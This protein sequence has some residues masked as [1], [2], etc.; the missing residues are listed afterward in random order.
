[1]VSKFL[2]S[3]IFQIAHQK[4]TLKE[5]DESNDDIYNI[6]SK[7]SDEKST[8]AKDDEDC[9]SNINELKATIALLTKEKEMLVKQNLEYVATIE[10]LERQLLFTKRTSTDSTKD[11]SFEMLN[12]SQS[13]LNG[14]QD[15]LLSQKFLLQSKFPEDKT[16]VDEDNHM[17]LSLS[18]D[19]QDNLSIRHVGSEARDVE[20]GGKNVEH[21]SLSAEA[22]NIELGL[23]KSSSR[24]VED[25]YQSVEHGPFSVGDELQNVEQ[26]SKFVDD[27][28]EDD[29]D[30]FMKEGELSSEMEDIFRRYTQGN[31]IL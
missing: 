26:Q 15:D 8:I 9:D 25:G 27:D 23:H 11:R 24:S 29:F 22:Q 17:V 19:S 30:I 6:A 2:F 14:S 18:H 12:G 13:S 16:T 10:Q 7:T 1:M 28:D 3:L 21:H 31:R 20:E 5:I 4:I